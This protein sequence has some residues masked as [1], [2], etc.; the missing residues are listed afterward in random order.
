MH[1][2]TALTDNDI[3][4]RTATQADG[5]TLVELISL[6]VLQLRAEQLPGALDPMRH[7]LTDSDDGPLSHTAGTTS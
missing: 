5:D 6:V 1:A 3:R 2:P 7:A 4:V